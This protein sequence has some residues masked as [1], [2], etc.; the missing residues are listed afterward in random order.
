MK[1]LKDILYKVRIVEVVGSTDIA[2]RSIHSDSRAVGGESLFIAIKGIQV[3]AHKY[4]AQ[5]IESGVI[6]I[7]CEELPENIIKGVTY[8]KVESTTVSLPVMASNFYD[9]PS[10]KLSL[11]GITGTNGKTTTVT[12]L[13]MLFKE[14]GYKVG[15]LS[16]VVN[17]IDGEEIPSTHTTPDP[18]QLNEL[19]FR[20][21]EENCSHCFMEVSSHA[22]IQER[23][24]G[25]TFKGGVF[26]NISHDHLD[27]H[28]TF[29][30]YIKAKKKFFDELPRSAFALINIDDKNGEVMVQNT[31]ARV[32]SFALKSMADYKAKVIENDISGLHLIIDD[33]EIWAR[34]IGEFNAYN[35]LVVYA[36]GILL[37]EDKLELLTVISSLSPVEGRFQRVESIESIKAIVDYAHTPDALKNV[38]EAIQDVRTGNGKI[39]TVIGCGG[40]RDN[41]KRPLMAKVA[42]EFS[43]KVILTSDNPRNEN[44]SDIIKQMEKG[45]NAMS[46]R[47][48]LS[49][50]D[51]KEA[52]KTACSLADHGDIILVAG[53]GHE[54]Y[55]EINGEKLPFNDVQ[56]L[57]DTLKMMEG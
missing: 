1:V 27:Y 28:G 55:Q 43:D 34:L 18:I 24:G 57:E 46:Q 5:T 51:R 33:N 41:E 35:L 7:V 16:T 4:I 42:C 32:L 48:T 20:M 15:L 10:E 3:D 56:V 21:V 40:N 8:V 14:L 47:K 29:K 22:L 31:S 38:L 6:A 54:K 50:V 17:M 52:I 45:V 2:V 13:Q 53:K 49:I 9:S 11:I 23:V 26:T 30:E 44:A 36:V 25:L 19:L 39:I 12:L 37:G